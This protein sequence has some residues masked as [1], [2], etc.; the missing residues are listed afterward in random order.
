MLGL[1]RKKGLCAALALCAILFSFSGCGFE[2]TEGPVWQY[3][4]IGAQ[5]TYGIR[6]DTLQT[7]SP[8]VEETVGA[9]F[10]DNKHDI[11][12]ED[13]ISVNN[14]SY[15][16]PQ[17][18]Q[19]ALLNTMAE[20]KF[21]TSFYV[22]DLETRA[23]FAYNPQKYFECASTIKAPYTLYLAR[24]LE[25]GVISLDDILEYKEHHFAEGSGSTQFSEFG[26]LFTLKA[27]LY[28]LLYNSDNVAYYML[29]EHAGYDG[30]NEMVSEMG[31]V[32][33]ISKRDHWVDITPQDLANV[34]L[35]IYDYRDACD[36]GRLLWTYLTTNLYNEFQVAMP[37]YTGSAHKSG[38]GF[39]GYHEAGIVFGRRT[40]LCIVM[41]ETGN[42]NNCLHRTIRN[43][44]DVINDYDI[45]LKNQGLN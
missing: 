23:S 44:D 25:A 10:L 32:N 11:F 21:E 36:E 3:C 1:Y 37:E 15:E 22:I 42:K 2:R 16:I 5:F 4:P 14:T 30:F 13:Q 41:T 26:T 19:D 24:Q 38:W 27:M 12:T 33:T 45:W 28:R 43:L 20:Y 6:S 40:Y 34:W 35:E 9:I 7:I 29:S 8:I 31:W 18:L 39:N 17:V